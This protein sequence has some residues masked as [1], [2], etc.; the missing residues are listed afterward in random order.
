MGY[1]GDW[2]ELILHPGKEV[3]KRKKGFDSAKIAAFMGAVALIGALV[4]VFGTNGTALQSLFGVSTPVLFSAIF[5][6]SVA[7]GLVII[8]LIHRMAAAL[9]GKGSFR[10]LLSVQ[11]EAT[12]PFSMLA[13]LYFMPY[14]GF[15]LAMLVSLASISVWI[16]LYKYLRG[17]YGLALE[18]AFTAIIV[19]A[20]LLGII[21]TVFMAG[22]M[23]SSFIA[24]AKAAGPT[25]T[26][27]AASNHFYSPMYGG[28]S[29]DFPTTWRYF[30]VANS[31][32]LGIAS[33]LTQNTFISLALFS[34]QAASSGGIV[35][36]QLQ[37][38][39]GMTLEQQCNTGLVRSYS[40]RVDTSGAQA[41]YVTMGR[42]DGCLLSGIEDR[43]GTVETMFATDGCA[44]GYYTMIGVSGNDTRPL[45]MIAE[46]FRCRSEAVK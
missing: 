20:F 15:V 46:S 28:Y 19:P 6:S 25:I 43:N 1:F 12:L 40:G 22:L 5:A 11:L 36:F 26:A 32:D 44:P 7:F 30:D 4:S 42:L 21:W 38:A 18:R 31:T 2:K 8:Y 9:G 23:V 33:I 24:G 14:A 37:R 17:V 39:S 29:F 10:G 3:L 34:D 41:K 13:L 35:A 27:A 16:V 45:K